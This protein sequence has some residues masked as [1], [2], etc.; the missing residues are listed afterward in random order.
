[1]HIFVYGGRQMLRCGVAH[2][3]VIAVT[4]GR[5]EGSRSLVRGIGLELF[6]RA[7]DEQAYGKFGYAFDRR[8]P[9]EKTS[10]LF[11]VKD[12]LPAPFLVGGRVEFEVRRCQPRPPISAPGAAG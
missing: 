10:N 6:F 4:S 12:N 11:E 7:E 1:M 9:R 5:V 3:D 8:D 2:D